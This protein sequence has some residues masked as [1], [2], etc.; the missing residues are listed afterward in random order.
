MDK[1]N[2]PKK[3]NQSGNKNENQS[4]QKN[5]SDKRGDSPKKRGGNTSPKKFAGKS[6]E[7]RKESADLQNG[8]LWAMSQAPKIDES[9]HSFQLAIAAFFTAFIILVVRASVYTRP[10]EQF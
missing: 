5:T 8:Y 4:S 9:T 1:S 2:Q 3:Q 6:T 7:I 10:M